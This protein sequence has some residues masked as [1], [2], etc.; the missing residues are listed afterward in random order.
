MAFLFVVSGFGMMMKIFGEFE[1]QG[2][3]PPAPGCFWDFCLDG[4]RER[5]GRKGFVG[6]QVAVCLSSV[7]FCLGA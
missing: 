5:K 2:Y 1:E 3:T 6:L 4:E 7:L